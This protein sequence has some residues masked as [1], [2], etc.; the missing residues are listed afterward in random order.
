M[1]DFIRKNYINIILISLII[2]SFILNITLSFRIIPIRGTV[3][4]FQH[5]YD[6]YD[7]TK[8]KNFL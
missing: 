7:G 2:F 4:D 6:M 1:N 5:F 8:K 3:D